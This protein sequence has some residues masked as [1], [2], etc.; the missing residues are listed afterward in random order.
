MLVLM[1]ETWRPAGPSSLRLTKIALAANNYV[2]L[3]ISHY[4]TCTASHILLPANFLLH[5]T[6]GIQLLLLYSPR[7]FSSVDCITCILLLH[8]CKLNIVQCA[9]YP[10]HFST[11]ALSYTLQYFLHV[12]SWKLWLGSIPCITSHCIFLTN[13]SIYSIPYSLLSCLFLT[14]GVFL[15][16]DHYYQNCLQHTTPAHRSLGHV[17]CSQASS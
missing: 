2:T 6:A 3:C 7:R 11:Q 4:F 16:P 1:S 14:C 8:Y 9:L 17:F 5:T 15:A 13:C 10:A 12:E